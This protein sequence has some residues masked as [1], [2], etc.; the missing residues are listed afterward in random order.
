MLDYEP[1]PN[2]PLYWIGR[3]RKN[4]FYYNRTYCDEDL[5]GNSDA[6]SDKMG[7]KE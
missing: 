5:A 6:R 3:Y 7:R 4:K 2:N 1:K